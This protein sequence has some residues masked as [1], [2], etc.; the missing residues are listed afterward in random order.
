MRKTKHF[1]LMAAML[2]CSLT[3][4]GEAVEIEGIWYNLT[5]PTREA[6]VTRN[7]NIG[8]H[9]ASY[10]ASS[11]TIHATVT[12][13][14]VIYSVTSI[15]DSAFQGC[16]NLATITIPESVTSIGE[17]AFNHC[18]SL[19]TI[20]IPEGVTNIGSSAFRGCRTYVNL[21]CPKKAIQQSSELLS[22]L[23][24]FI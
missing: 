12:Y 17:W 8:D 1:L 7:P 18:I 3:A 23:D 21:P 19:I 24:S 10:S 20:N 9:E 4:K 15:G 14:D 11:I 5:I 13:E 16:T 22:P 6:E 2:L